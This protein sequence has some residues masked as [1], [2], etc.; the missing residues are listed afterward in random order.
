MKLQ[1]GEPWDDMGSQYKGTEEIDQ[2]SLVSYD[3]YLK[4]AGW[5]GWRTNGQEA[6]SELQRRKIEAFRITL[7]DNIENEGIRYKAHI[8]DVGWTDWA[9]NGNILGTPDSDKRMEAIQIEL[10]N[11]SEYDVQYRVHVQDIG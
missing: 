2:T 3:A 11:G 4:N 10:T 6:G 1:E 8:Q 7:S 9:E 5:T